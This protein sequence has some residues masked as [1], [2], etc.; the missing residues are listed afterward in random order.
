MIDEIKLKQ[1]IEEKLEQPIIKILN[2]SIDTNGDCLVTFIY[3]DKKYN[4]I[5]EANLTLYKIIIDDL[6]NK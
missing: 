2:Y 5:I 1:K 3:Q 4:H 6:W